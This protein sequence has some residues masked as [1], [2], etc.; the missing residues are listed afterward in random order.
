MGSLDNNAI[1][2]VGS[3]VKEGSSF[4]VPFLYLGARII[5]RMHVENPSSESSQNIHLA[6]YVLE[7]FDTRWKVAGKSSLGSKDDDGANYASRSIFEGSRSKTNERW[8]VKY[9]T[10]S[11]VTLLTTAL[12]LESFVFRSFSV[13]EF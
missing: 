2:P 7:V 13:V 1:K 6:R 9:G 12:I 8:N 11:G 10:Y 5:N 3:C 4:L